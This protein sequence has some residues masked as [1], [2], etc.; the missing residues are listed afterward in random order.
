MPLD[1]ICHEHCQIFALFVKDFRTSVVRSLIQSPTLIF[2]IRS[3]PWVEL[4]IG[5]DDSQAVLGSQ[6]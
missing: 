5:E 2:G 1:H 4:A 6:R 3:R